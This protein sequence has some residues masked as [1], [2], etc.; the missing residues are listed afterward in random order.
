[1]VK[2]APGRKERKPRPNPL[3]EARVSYIDYKDT[4]LLR[5]FISDRGKI[6]S[7][8]VTRLTVQQQRAMATAIKN[9]REMALLPYTSDKAGR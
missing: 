7:R 3:H 9:A 1:M 6:R 5:K 8:R 2:I 4:T